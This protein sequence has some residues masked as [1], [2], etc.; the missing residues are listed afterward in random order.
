MVLVLYVLLFSQP[1]EL[2]LL[3]SRWNIL[4]TFC[5]QYAHMIYEL[6]LYM[7]LAG[8]ILLGEVWHYIQFKV[9]LYCRYKISHLKSELFNC[10]N[11]V[12]LAIGFPFIPE[13]DAIPPE[14]IVGFI[15]RDTD[16]T[17]NFWSTSLVNKLR[18]NIEEY[19]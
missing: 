19:D 8:G 14:N 17:T 13:E 12:F 11:L 5:T 15:C 7:T 9:F 3:Q 6:F 10:L 1:L 18:I 4:T 2:M 16:F